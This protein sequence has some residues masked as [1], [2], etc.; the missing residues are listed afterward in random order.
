MIH[1]NISGVI[2]QWS[3][4]HKILGCCWSSVFNGN[5]V[6]KGIKIKFNFLNIAN[7]QWL[8]WLSSLLAI[9]WMNISHCINEM[10]DRNY[11]WPWLEIESCESKINEVESDNV[12][13]NIS[14]CIDYQIVRN[15]I[16]DCKLGALIYLKEQIQ[17]LLVI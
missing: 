7:L 10:R 13:N 2:C 5:I 1:I 12:V 16:L 6:K 4:N 8:Y 11:F 9:L 17:I 15:H 14:L 3:A